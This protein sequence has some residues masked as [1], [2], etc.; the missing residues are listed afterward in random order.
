MPCDDCD[1]VQYCSDECQQDHRPEHETRCKERAAEL[2]EEI[3]FRQP[4]SSHLGDCPIC[5]VPLPIIED[6][7][8]V[9]LYPCC[10]KYVCDGCSHT[11]NE[12]QY[13][14]KREQ[15]KCP[16]CRNPVTSND[17]EFNKYLLNRVAANDPGALSHMGFVYGDEGDYDGA[18]KYLTKAVELGDAHAH[19][20]LSIM[21]MKGEGVEQDEKKQVFHFEEAAIRGHPYARYNL[22]VHERIRTGEIE[23]AVKHLI[24]AA[25]LGYDRSITLLKECY[26]DGDIEKDDFAAALR[27][28]H[29]AVDATKSPQREEVAMKR[30]AAELRDE[31][32][33]KQP[34][35]SHHGDCS[36]CCLPLPVDEEYQL[37]QCCY[38]KICQGCLYASYKQ[39]IEEGRETNYC[40]FCPNS[41]PKSWANDPVAWNQLGGELADKGDFDRAFVCFTKAVECGNCAEAHLHLASMYHKEQG[42]RKDKRK[43]LYH[44]EEAAIGGHAEAR[45]ILGDIEEGKK[46]TK[47]AIK[48]WIIAAYMGYGASL[49]KIKGLYEDGL[50]SKET[51]A[52]AL[53]GHQAA[54][55]KT[56]SPQREEGRKFMRSMQKK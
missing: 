10:G 29:A 33:F 26:K 45:H 52:L 24:I 39:K 30:R 2:R 12:R 20:G 51:L 4:E 35:S 56:K 14:E 55:D 22:A 40:P 28:H 13:E 1:L 11:D 50:V 15:P 18:F 38:N 7:N 46:R 25:N 47:R 27:A 49:E 44:L 3:L 9:S 41:R 31:I 21:Y 8:S 5:C 17:E 6:G 23:R 42:V 54:L 34:E 16:F 48:H 32:L 19:Y 43:E 53:R 37:M 36:I